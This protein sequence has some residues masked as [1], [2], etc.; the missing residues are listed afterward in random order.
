MHRPTIDMASTDTFLLPQVN[1]MT[2]SGIIA[3]LMASSTIAG[4]T[5]AKAA[6]CRIIF[7]TGVVTAMVSMSAVASRFRKLTGAHGEPHAG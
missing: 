2:I 3:Y 4:T 5:A 1:R 7:G 6:L